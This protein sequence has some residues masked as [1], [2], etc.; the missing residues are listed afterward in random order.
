MSWIVRRS[1]VIGERRET[2]ANFCA[3]LFNLWGLTHLLSVLLPLENHGWGKNETCQKA[4]VTLFISS[5]S[6]TAS[7]SSLLFFSVSPTL[8][9]SSLAFSSSI[10]FLFPSEIWTC[11]GWLQCSWNNRN[12]LTPTSDRREGGLSCRSVWRFEEPLVLSG[13][14]WIGSA[15]LKG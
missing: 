12:A 14:A 6:F 2:Q 1:S 15:E 10:Y 13:S 5:F 4:T 7:H 11:S 3:P 9:L 8:A